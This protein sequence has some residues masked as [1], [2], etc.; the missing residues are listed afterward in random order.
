[1]VLVVMNVAYSLSAYPAG[2][3]ADRLGRWVGL[4]LSLVLLIIADLVIAGTSTIPMALLGVA[5]WGLHM[6]FSQGTFSALVADS[7]P[8]HLRGTAFGVY[9]LA[10]GGGMLTASAVAGLVW[11]RFGPEATFVVGAGFAGVALA[12]VTWRITRRG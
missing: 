10:V 3:M 4:A 8:P 7:A 6:G 9:N 5:I 11:S 1:V 12:G 2:V